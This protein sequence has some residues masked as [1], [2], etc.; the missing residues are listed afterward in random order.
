MAAG[1]KIVLVAVTVAV[2]SGSSES[3]LGFGFVGRSIWSV[4]FAGSEVG[5]GAASTL[6]VLAIAVAV[7]WSSSCSSG[8]GCRPWI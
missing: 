5:G 7:S 3:S 2:V 1:T 8:S 6:V 4:G